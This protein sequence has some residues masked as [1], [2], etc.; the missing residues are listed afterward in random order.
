MWKGSGKAAQEE[1]K[2]NP[3]RRSGKGAETF[4][5]AALAALIQVQSIY[6]TRISKDDATR[7]K[8]RTGKKS[9]HTQA[10]SLKDERGKRGKTPPTQ[11]H[12]PNTPMPREAATTAE[13]HDKRRYAKVK[14]SASKTAENR[15]EK[16]P[17]AK[18]AIYIFF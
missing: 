1:N 9:A 4:V 2:R 8:A 16:S 17:S 14:R 6:S 5:A 15:N 11:T 3:Q 18:M 7:A 13:R 10:H 12:S